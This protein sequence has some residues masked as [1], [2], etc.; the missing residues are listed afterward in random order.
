M[1]IPFMKKSNKRGV[2][3]LQ[4]YQQ[5]HNQLLGQLGI[6]ERQKKVFL[7]EVKK[8]DGQINGIH[9]RMDQVANDAQK[10][11]QL[12]QEELAKTIKKGEANA[13]APKAVPAAE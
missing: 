1:A 6:A 9:Q 11:Q 3:T 12:A 4:Q 13:E 5:E 8:L 2:K 7:Q 10:A